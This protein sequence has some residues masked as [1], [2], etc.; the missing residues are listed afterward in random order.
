MLSAKIFAMPTVV[1]SA[2]LLCFTSCVNEEYD[3][4]DGIDTSI[5]IAGDISLPVGSTEFIPIGD[6]LKLDSEEGSTS[7]LQCDEDGNYFIVINGGDPVTESVTVN[8]IS[9]G[10]DGL[11]GGGGFQIEIPVKGSISGSQLPDT[12]ITIDNFIDQ[13]TD[14]T[15]DEE[16]SE[17]AT[18]VKAIR[19]VGL[20]APISIDLALLDANESPIE[21]RLRINN[22]KITFPSCILLEKS[23]SDSHY[24]LENSH[25]IV[26]NNMDIQPGSSIGLIMK[27]I[28]LDGLDGEDEG[29]KNGRLK[30][31]EQI[32]ISDLSISFYPKDFGS[33]VSGLPG[34]ILLDMAMNVADLNVKG[35]VAVVEPDLDINVDP[36]E[37]GELPE[38]I[39]GDNIVLDLYNPV[40]RLDIDFQSNDRTPT[41]E[42]PSFLLN[43][44]INATKDNEPTMSEPIHIGSKD[45]QS[46]SAAMIEKGSNTIYIS[47]IGTGYDDGGISSVGEH[48]LDLKVANLSDLLKTIPDTISI[49]NISVTAPLKGNETDGYEDEDYSTILF[50]ENDPLNI[51]FSFNYGV[52][53]PL[54]FGEDLNI[55]YSTDVNGWNDMFNPSSDGGLKLSMNEVVLKFRFISTIP[56]TMGVSASAI[57]L[58]GEV[59]TEGISVEMLDANGNPGKISGGNQNAPASSDLM[60]RLSADDSALEKFD[61]LRLN[62]SATSPESDYQG[63][64]LNQNQGIK[65]EK[66][67]LNIKGGASL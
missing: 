1:A 28:N 34:N 2:F 48:V 50:P 15:I 44:D 17:V 20:E 42:F 22:A 43:A 21:G 19:K 56:F 14:V 31:N 53:T 61:G 27:E 29:Y 38:F 16:V 36:V 49:E 30:V 63:V 57:N 47:R 37:I 12:Q 3:F 58:S 51:N 13:N 55:S 5:D 40:I 60:V 26:I 59:F 25:T 11:I 33:T 4:R 66:I 46:P 9:I 7:I 24:S 39:A 64:T 41:G 23:G 18:L 35:L 67:V 6:F 32:T 54:A 65:L 10:S 62:I 8:Q 52:N 45:P